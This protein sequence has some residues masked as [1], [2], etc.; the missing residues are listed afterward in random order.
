MLLHGNP[1]WSFL[2]RGL[3]RQLRV[4]YRCI[5]PDLSGFGLSP[6][7]PQPLRPAAHAEI[8]SA[9]LDA[10]GLDA[11]VLVAHDWG[12]PIGLAA[13][14]RRPQALRGLVL[15]NSFAWPLRGASAWRLRLFSVLA[16]GLPALLASRCCNAFLKLGLPL[17]I[18][19]RPLSAAVLDGYRVPFRD[20]DRRLAIH[21]LA[22]ELLG[23]TEFLSGV[24]QGLARFRD[25]PVLLCW[26]GRDPFVGSYER[27]RFEA[28]FPDHESLLLP[29]AGHFVPED[30]SAAMA[31]AML[32]WLGS[33]R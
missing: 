22:R 15:A 13:A 31:E 26:G 16:G 32:A 20:R 7:P 2:Y 12:G 24:E 14:R 25:R 6:T 9:L 3:I 21:V 19:R 17:A 27:R 11:Y 1:T 30:A 29:E 23:S 18:R 10:L 5:A 28:A 33:R 8:I 4:H